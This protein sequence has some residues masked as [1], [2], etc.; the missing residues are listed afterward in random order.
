MYNIRLIVLLT[1]VEMLNGFLYFMENI[2][3][4]KFN[5]LTAIK[6]I[7]FFKRRTY[8]LFKCDCGNNKIIN[9]YKV[10]SG[11]TKSCGCL[12]KLGNNRIH[13]MRKTRFY[14]IHRGIKTRCNNLKSEKYPIYGGRGIK[15]LWNSFKEFKND[16]YESYLKHI[17]EFGEKQ[18][19][20]DRIN[21][22]GNYCPE[23]CRWVNLKEQAR[24]RRNNR[25]ITFNKK[26]MCI[27]NW[28]EELKVRYGLIWARLND[29]KWT[30]KK[31][32]TANIR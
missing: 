5:K 20:I 15:C 18:T 9:K 22:N 17:K 12:F 16:M 28:E 24:N 30:I 7:K 25:F 2:K 21:N 4:Q 23:N 29:S 31:A 14:N 32:L 19:Q 27:R 13:N 1:K 8:W 11:H 10:K 3:N 6:Y 26:T